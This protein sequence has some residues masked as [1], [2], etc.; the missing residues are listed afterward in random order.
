VIKV[1]I[2][3]LPRPTHIGAR[4]PSAGGTGRRQRF[5]RQPSMVRQGSYHG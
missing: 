1:R 3:G 5:G 4:T 2:P